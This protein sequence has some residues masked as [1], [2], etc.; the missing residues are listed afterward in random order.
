MV[1]PSF[2][3]EL[4]TRVVR[5]FGNDAVRGS[6][7]QSGRRAIRQLCGVLGQGK[8]VAITPDGPRGPSEV[9]QEGLL[10]LARISGAPVIPFHYEAGRQWQLRSWDQHKL[11][12][13]FA[14]LQVFYGDP[15]WV[16]ADME[17]ADFDR[18]RDILAGALAENARNCRAAVK[19]GRAHV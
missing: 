6:T 14:R 1:S 11:P 15:V 16:P 2:D 10:T 7:S 13:P 3:G 9:M 12:K 8:S 18:Y 17:A 19:I 4:I 5:L